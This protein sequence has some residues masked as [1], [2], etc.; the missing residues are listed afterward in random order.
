MTVD[1][2]ESI[3]LKGSMMRP[4]WAFNRQTSGWSIA[5]KRSGPRG[6]ALVMMRHT[7]K[8]ASAFSI[9]DQVTVQGKENTF[10]DGGPLTKIEKAAAKAAND[11]SLVPI[12]LVQED[13]A[14]RFGGDGNAEF[15]PPLAPLPK[16]EN[17]PLQWKKGEKVEVGAL[18]EGYV[19]SWYEAEIIALSGGPEPGHVQVSFD[20]LTEEDGSPVKEGASQ[21]VPTPEAAAGGGGRLPSRSLCGRRS[22]A[23]MVQ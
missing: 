22:V 2:Q 12:L 13:G 11:P 5:N 7:P 8:G 15:A 16:D 1:K 4:M 9:V 17:P 10:S 23:V 20:T 21:I 19:G 18:D 6:A 3:K 14:W